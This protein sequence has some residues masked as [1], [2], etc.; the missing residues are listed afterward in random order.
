M[1]VDRVFGLLGALMNNPAPLITVD[2]GTAVTVNA[3]DEH[4]VCLG[5]AI[6]AGVDTQMKALEISTSGL[7]RVDIYYD[8]ASCGIDTAQALRIGIIRGIA[9]GIKEIVKRI[10]S[11]EFRGAPYTIVFTG[12]SSDKLLTEM[13]NWDVPVKFNQYLVLEGILSVIKKSGIK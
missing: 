10:A 5:G 6:F 2:C 12:G 8:D 13:R 9:G 7:K 3:I 1:G 4:G 11:S